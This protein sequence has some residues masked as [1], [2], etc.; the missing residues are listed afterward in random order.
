MGLDETLILV[1]TLYYNENPQKIWKE[2]FIHENGNM[3][4]RY[5]NETFLHSYGGNNN[6]LLIGDILVTER[7]IFHISL[8]TEYSVESIK[9]A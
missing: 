9:K 3:F 7:K 2:I 1:A 6:S 8:L 5:S 4:G